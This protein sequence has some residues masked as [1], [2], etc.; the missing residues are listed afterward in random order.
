MAVQPT[1]VC[2]VSR[3][4]L[5]SGRFIAALEAS[6]GPGDHLEIIVDRRHGGSSGETDL[7]EDR[8]RQRQVAFALEANGFA[9]VPASVDPTSAAPTAD[10]TLYSLL[11]FEAPIER[12]PPVDDEDEKRLE[13]IRSFQRRQPGTL[14]TIFEPLITHAS[15]SGSARVVRLPGSD[16]DPGSVSA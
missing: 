3:D 11:R 8:R 12:V 7:K 15:P 5:R 1:R 13:S 9:I 14:I 10:R 2:I 16:P 4:P 6:V